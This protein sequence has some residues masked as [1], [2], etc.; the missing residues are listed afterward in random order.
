MQAKWPVL[1]IFFRH[2]YRLSAAMQIYLFVLLVFWGSTASGVA[3]TAQGVA[4]FYGSTGIA[5]LLSIGIVIINLQKNGGIRKRG[6]TLEADLSKLEGGLS[7]S[8][9]ELEQPSK[10]II[11]KL[12]P[13]D[14]RKHRCLLIARGISIFAAIYEFIYY[15]NRWHQYLPKIVTW[16]LHFGTWFTLMICVS[17]FIF[18]MREQTM[19]L[20][21]VGSLRVKN[22]KLAE[23]LYRFGQSEYQNM[24]PILNKIKQKNDNTKP[25]LFHEVMEKTENVSAKAKPAYVLLFQGMLASVLV[26]GVNALIIL[27]PAWLL[28]ASVTVPLLLAATIWGVLTTTIIACKVLLN[29]YDDHKA[30]TAYRS[31]IHYSSLGLW[32]ILT[33][34]ATVVN[35][36]AI[37][38]LVYFTTIDLS[39]LVVIG[40]V[41]IVL[42]CLIGCI[43]WWKEGA[44]NQNIVTTNKQ[45]ARYKQSFVNC[46][47]F[48]VIEQK[49]DETIIVSWDDKHTSQD[50]NN[51]EMKETV[52]DYLYAI[53]RIN[54]LAA[55]RAVDM[56]YKEFERRVVAFLWN[57]LSYGSTIFY[58]FEIFIR[59]L[60]PIPTVIASSPETYV[61][62]IV[63]TLLFSVYLSYVK[64]ENSKHD[65]RTVFLL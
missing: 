17:A 58:T 44:I 28:S 53:E 33:L 35:V 20:D 32:S 22:K 43:A 7:D 30:D 21:Y 8:K 4:F 52:I 10:Q 11:T 60:L 6:E 49:S 37:V 46:K 62:E 47:Q 59:H 31:R 36:A 19:Y 2:A 25:E 51:N 64:Y 24:Q 40:A 29:I 16:F 26:G 61:I 54:T 39:W 34:S 3:S 14:A 23:R 45:A 55:Y 12:L 63:L 9:P 57:L 48:L 41:F 65:R 15:L 1:R 56:P 50:N 38:G 13:T 27:S 18:S 42:T 5:I